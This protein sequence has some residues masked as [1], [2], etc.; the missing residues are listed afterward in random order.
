MLLVL[1]LFACDASI[2]S[3]IFSLSHFSLFFFCFCL[4]FTIYIFFQFGMYSF[5]CVW[6]CVV[7]S[8]EHTI[9]KKRNLEHLLNF[10][11]IDDFGRT[12]EYICAVRVCNSLQS[13]FAF[14]F[15]FPSYFHTAFIPFHFPNILS[16]QL[17]RL[18]LLL[19][20]YIALIAFKT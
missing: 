4:I 17:A 12:N 11:S 18:N 5:G 1:I 19:R 20:I 9:L 8:P 10:K 6:W 16:F 15:I 13:L 2:V 14:S 3:H 7:Q